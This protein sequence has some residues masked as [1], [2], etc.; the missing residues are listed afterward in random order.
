MDKVAV[1]CDSKERW[2][3]LKTTLDSITGLHFENL[4]LD[5]GTEI[6]IEAAIDRLQINDIDYNYLVIDSTSLGDEE[7]LREISDEVSIRIPDM[8]IASISPERLVQESQE[9]TTS[10]IHLHTPETNDLRMIADLYR[11]NKRVTQEKSYLMLTTDQARLGGSTLDFLTEPG[12]LEEFRAQRMEHIFIML[13]ESVVMANR[14]IHIT[15]GGGPTSDII[16]NLPHIAKEPVLAEKRQ[17]ASKYI[18]SIRQAQQFSTEINLKTGLRIAKTLLPSDLIRMNTGDNNKSISQVIEDKMQ[19]GI[20]VCGPPPRALRLKRPHLG[21][22][23]PD[24]D[25]FYWRAFIRGVNDEGRPMLF[26]KR[27]DQLYRF[28]WRE[29]IAAGLLTWY[30]TQESNKPF[31]IQT[32][33][34]IAKDRDPD[35]NPMDREGEDRKGSHLLS[36]AATKEWLEDERLACI[37]YIQYAAATAEETWRVLPKRGYKNSKERLKWRHIVT[38]KALHHKYTPRDSSDANPFSALRKYG[39][40]AL[41]LGFK[42]FFEPKKRLPM[43]NTRFRIYRQ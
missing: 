27:T 5:N 22:Y 8:P 14:Y 24:L 7:Y 30:E 32:A 10:S 42:S 3:D 9:L 29:S 34:N 11:F 13:F 26:I 17:A 19:R 20:V 12:I 25:S 43:E 15:I 40:E 39:E 36:D 18:N 4:C 37:P 16:S 33:I 41:R 1:F 23:T 38:G 2:N 6:T 28:D 31:N 21:M 35:G